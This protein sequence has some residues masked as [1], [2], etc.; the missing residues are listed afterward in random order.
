[1]VSIKK[2]IKLNELT[3][4]VIYYINTTSTYDAVLINNSLLTTSTDSQ[5]S[6]TNY[7]TQAQNARIGKKRTE[8]ITLEFDSEFYDSISQW[9][10]SLNITFEQLIYAFIEFIVTDNSNSLISLLINE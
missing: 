1:M 9:C 7:V 5:S 4:L 10:G 2:I 8:I 6:M 3:S